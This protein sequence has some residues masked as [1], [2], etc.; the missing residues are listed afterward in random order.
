ME[1]FTGTPTGNVQLSDMEIRGTDGMTEEE[2]DHHY[3]TTPCAYCRKREGEW[4]GDVC[5]KCKKL[6][7][8]WD[9]YF[10][11]V[12]SKNNEV[13]EEIKKIQA[14]L[15]FQESISL[16]PDGSL[17]IHFGEEDSYTID[18]LSNRIKEEQK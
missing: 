2:R 12:S 15:D 7:L 4:Y 3:R 9:K 16:E 13:D 11:A 14:S 5:P 17:R 8:E 10:K 6:R 18:A 1:S